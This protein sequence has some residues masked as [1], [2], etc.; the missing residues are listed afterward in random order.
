M[1][2]FFFKCIALNRPVSTL[3]L[4]QLQ[5][6]ESDQKRGL[7]STVAECTNVLVVLIWVFNHVPPVDR[8]LFVINAIKEEIVSRVEDSSPRPTNMAETLEHLIKETL[9]ENHGHG[10]HHI[11]N[12]KKIIR[13]KLMHL[14]RISQNKVS[15]E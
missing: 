15:L 3:K 1:D 10:H 4:F 11:M 5:I 9:G 12:N 13:G 7:S 6:F 8:L 2:F 14:T